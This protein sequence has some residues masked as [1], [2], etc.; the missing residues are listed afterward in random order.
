MVSVYG[1]FLAILIPGAISPM[2]WI[3]LAGSESLLARTNCN[4]FM[5]AEYPSNQRKISKFSCSAPT[6]TFSLRQLWYFPLLSKAGTS[7]REIPLSA[8]IQY[9]RFKNIYPDVGRKLNSC[10][11]VATCEAYMLRGQGDKYSQ[12]FTPYQE[13]CAPPVD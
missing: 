12:R 7:G 4:V 5:G 3:E 9:L 8:F 1:T 13:I 6:I 11:A 10:V 2:L